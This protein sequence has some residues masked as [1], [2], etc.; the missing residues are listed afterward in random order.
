[1]DPIL[2]AKAFQLGIL[3]LQWMRENNELDEKDEA[4]A[5]RIYDAMVRLNVPIEDRLIS[6]LDAIINVDSNDTQDR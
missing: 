6:K 5:T 4:E 3:G 2:A 1:M